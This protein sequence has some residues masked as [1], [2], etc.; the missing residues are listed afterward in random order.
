MLLQAESL[1]EPV[2]ETAVPLYNTQ[3]DPPCE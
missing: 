1:G 2:M 3:L